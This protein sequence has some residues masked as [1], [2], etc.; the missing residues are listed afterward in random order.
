MKEEIEEKIVLPNPEVKRDQ[1]VKEC[2]GCNKMFSDENIGD[3][4]IAYINPK[5]KWL[6]YRIEAVAVGSKG[7]EI[8]YYYNPCPLASHVKHHIKNVDRK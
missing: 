5:V 8:I 1:C 6:N 2:Q 7:K 3:V 4:C